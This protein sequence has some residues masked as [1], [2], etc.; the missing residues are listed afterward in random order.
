MVAAQLAICRGRIEAAAKNAGR[1][2][3]DITL[4]AVTKSV[5][6]PLI[7]EALDAGCAHIGESRLQ[8]ALMKYEALAAYV[9]GR[10][11]SLVWHMIGHVQSNKVK[12]AVRIFDMI[13]SIDSVRLACQVDK[14]A[15]KL[16]KVQDI[17]LEVKTS[18][19]ATKYGFPPEEVAAAVKETVLLKNVR[20]RGLMTIAPP[21]D[22][23]EKARPYFCKLKNV[24]E[25]VN[26]GL[27]TMDHRLSVLS[28]G[29]T[30]DY[31]AAIWEGATHVRIGRGIFGER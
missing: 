5:T 30:D 1:R 7:R 26:R 20:V 25:E 14:E 19:E 22:G 27:S 31:E 18:P 15:F 28:M 12:D 13:H 17:L 29:M 8:E 23:S 24:F 3:Q 4:V 16:G 9:R 2:S 10:G 21:V 6:L 11:N